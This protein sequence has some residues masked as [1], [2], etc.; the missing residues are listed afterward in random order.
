MFKEI[1]HIDTMELGFKL[2]LPLGSNITIW[3]DLALDFNISQAE[4]SK[5]G[6]ARLQPG[7]F[8]QTEKLFEII[9][10]PFPLYAI[11]EFRE[12]LKSLNVM[13]AYKLMED[14]IIGE[15]KEKESG[16]LI[17]NLHIFMN[18]CYFL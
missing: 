16:F 9:S 2:V 13:D 14:K 5:I 18:I 10:M 7:V 1:S 17:F 6:R 11:G 12:K 3:K 4:V 8:S 15:I